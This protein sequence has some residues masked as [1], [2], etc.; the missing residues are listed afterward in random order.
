MGDTGKS[1]E[2]AVSSWN[3]IRLKP[4]AGPNYAAQ[5]TNIVGKEMVLRPVSQNNQ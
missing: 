3:K 5:L 2:R 1:Y 4:E